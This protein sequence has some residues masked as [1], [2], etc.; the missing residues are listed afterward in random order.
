MPGVPTNIGLFV[1][2]GTELSVTW[3]PPVS[4]GGSA[5]T[6]YRVEWD[7]AP[8]VREEQTIATDVWLGANDVQTITS[9]ATTVNEVQT[10]ITTATAKPSI[11]TITSTASAFETIGGT[12]TIGITTA[13]GLATS[14][15]LQN[16][17]AWNAGT[18]P[19]HTTV[20]EAL[21]AMGVATTVTRTGPDGQ[22]GYV[23]TV[24]FTSNLPTP[25]L[26][27]ASSLSGLG[28]SIVVAEV[29]AANQLGGTFALSFRGATTA[30]IKV[31]ATDA[32][33][34]AALAELATITSVIVTR[35]VTADTQGGYTWRV[36][37]TSD[38]QAG[39]MPALVPTLSALTGSGANVTVC[40]DGSTV[41]PCIAG[42]STRG[43]QIAGTFS[44]TDSFSNVASS[45]SYDSSAAA[46]AT[47]IGALSNGACTVTRSGP[48]R[49]RGYVWTISFTSNLGLL[50]NLVPNP[51]GLTG[52]GVT[53][54]Q[55]HPLPGTIQTVQSVS[56]SGLLST[57]APRGSITLTVNAA[58]TTA[59]TI[60]ATCVASTNVA[61]SLKALSTVV[62]AVVVCSTPSPTTMVFAVTFSRNAG[63]VPAIVMATT[64]AAGTGTVAIVGGI[65]QA[66]TRGARARA[67]F[68]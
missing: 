35:S 19:I 62:D 36:T 33:V 12:F 42:S 13:S 26:T 45:I 7:T 14:G 66:G 52:T 10:F 23:W 8:G 16:N 43:N 65:N 25:L 56:L 22:G 32:S 31:T 11:Q 34:Q 3:G 27:V 44:V 28:S 60:G 15:P 24:T 48:D 58:T 21:T 47:K 46:M 5:V 2:S 30:P 6:S 63:V 50:P 53:L 57:G 1:R 37:F 40:A 41:A 49:N 4:D 67:E 51:T 38:D 59:I 54:T 29:Q 17:A 64:L 61:T 55:G 18:G 20:Q 9:T 68:T 39:D